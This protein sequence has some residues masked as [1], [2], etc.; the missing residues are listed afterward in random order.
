MLLSP[1]VY[2]YHFNGRPFY[3]PDWKTVAKYIESRKQPDEIIIVDSLEVRMN[4]SYY[5]GKYE[6]Y[7]YLNNQWLNTNSSND[8]LVILDSDTYENVLGGK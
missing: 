1:A 6:K 3:K 4:L 8:G 7:S 2:N 5:L